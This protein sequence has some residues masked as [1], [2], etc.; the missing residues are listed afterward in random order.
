MEFLNRLIF[1]MGVTGIAFVLVGCGVS[2]DEY[3]KIASE[4]YQTKIEIDKTKAELTTT[5]KEFANTKTEMNKIMAELD[6]T[7]MELKQA[8]DEFVEREK[9]CNEAQSLLKIDLEKQVKE[10]KEIRSQL[11][12]SRL[13]VAYLKEE[14]GELLNRLMKTAEELDMI[15][16]A[17][18]ILRT[19]MAELTKEKKRLRKLSEN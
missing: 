4:L 10:G 6:K 7:K 9:A 12:I 18:Q 19:Q 14:L 1:L 13:E 2:K 8:N 15:Q 11:V 3:E 5:Q 17:N 16:N